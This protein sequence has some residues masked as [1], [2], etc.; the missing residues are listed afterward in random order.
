MGRESTLQHTA[1]ITATS[2]CITS[3]PLPSCSLLPV[4]PLRKNQDWEGKSGCERERERKKEKERE[5][6]LERERE[7]LRE[8]GRERV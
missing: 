7:S 3:S 2:P 5:G 8:R 4:V 6:V 1:N